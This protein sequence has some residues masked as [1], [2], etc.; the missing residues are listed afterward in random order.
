[1]RVTIRYFE[2]CRANIADFGSGS[3]ARR[4]NIGK[5][6][7]YL[8]QP[9]DFEDG[10]HRFLQAGERE[11]AAVFLDILHGFNQGGEARAIDVGHARKIDN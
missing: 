1:V 3:G 5:N 6:P 2:E 4:V 9:R 7:E 10:A 8:I 11:L